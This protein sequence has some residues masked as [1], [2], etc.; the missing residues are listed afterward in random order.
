MLSAPAEAMEVLI[1]HEPYSIAAVLLL[2]E[3][4]HYGQLVGGV[5]FGPSLIQ[6]RKDLDD[7]PKHT[8]DDADTLLLYTNDNLSDHIWNQQMPLK[9]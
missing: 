5:G 4:R 1:S 2:T 3:S 6:P 9:Y 7:T 8:G